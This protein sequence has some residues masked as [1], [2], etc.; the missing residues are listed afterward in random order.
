MIKLNLGCGKKTLKSFI[1]IDKFE[2]G[3]NII[4][5]DITK[6][7]SIEKGTVDFIYSAHSLICVPETKLLDTFWASKPLL[8][9]NE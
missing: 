9:E 1:N 3:K 5:D 4:N 2:K 8:T 6:L 7:E